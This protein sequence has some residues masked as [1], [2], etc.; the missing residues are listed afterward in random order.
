MLNSVL[1]FLD[2][3]RDSL[4][5]ASLCLGPKMTKRETRAQF[6]DSSARKFSLISLVPLPLSCQSLRQHISP[7]LRSSASSP[8]TV[9]TVGHKA[10]HML[11]NPRIQAGMG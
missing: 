3:D 9:H 7:S 11:S 5:S 1:S 10:S 4:F 2:W 6:T 8:T